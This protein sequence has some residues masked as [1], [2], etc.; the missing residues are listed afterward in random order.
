MDKRLDG[1]LY[2]TGKLELLGVKFK[3]VVIHAG[4]GDA[5]LIEATDNTSKHFK[6]LMYRLC[7]CS[8]N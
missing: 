7:A 8:L 2:N 4:F 5:T 6:R 3:V 1:F